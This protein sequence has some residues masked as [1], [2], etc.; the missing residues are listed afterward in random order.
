MADPIIQGDLF[1][2]KTAGLL[3]TKEYIPGLWAQA[4]VYWSS[5]PSVWQ[6]FY[7]PIILTQ[8]QRV[9]VRIKEVK[10]RVIRAW[11]A[12]TTDTWDKI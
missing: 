7:E 1:P 4:L 9:W 8:R 5:K 11:K 6:P 2:L 12:L 3:H 10:A